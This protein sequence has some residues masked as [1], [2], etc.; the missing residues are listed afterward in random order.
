MSSPL[1][2]HIR[3]VFFDHDDTL[4]GTIR[5]KWA[6]HKYIASK[7]YSKSLTDEELTKHWG[8][9]FREMICLLYETEDADKAVAYNVESQ[10][11]YPKEIF[12]ATIQTLRHIHSTGRRIG[13]ITATTRERFEYD[14]N[15]HKVP[16]ELIDY[17]QTADDTNYH[18]PDPRVFELAK[19]WLQEQL[20]EPGE[21]V[22]IGDGL[23][24]MRAA[25]GAG[26]SFIGVTTGLVSAQEFSQ[27]GA[28]YMTGIAELLS[29]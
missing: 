12:A 8:K 11:E 26:F 20:I 21:V 22:Y 7:Y 17:N 4:V 28:P 29:A 13:V 14:L 2:E 5:N 25:L 9:P 27:E 24:D 1:P 19:V 18:K 16:R 15:L 3:A 6:Q 10:K 23:H